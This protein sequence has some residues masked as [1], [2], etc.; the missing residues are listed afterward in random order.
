MH[1]Y[2]SMNPSKKKNGDDWINEIDYV[3][4]FKKPMTFDLLF[5]LW[6]M[7]HQNEFCTSMYPYVNKKNENE[8]KKN[9]H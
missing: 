6:I 9:C 4:I 5:L 7:Y 2:M 3:K 8:K 1:G